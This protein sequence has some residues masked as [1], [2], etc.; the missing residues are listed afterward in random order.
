VV[1]E[2]ARTF[3]VNVDEIINHV[4]KVIENISYKEVKKK[5]LLLPGGWISFRMKTV[6]RALLELSGYQNGNIERYRPNIAQLK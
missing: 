1:G 4:I 2:T 5:N 6:L 3:L